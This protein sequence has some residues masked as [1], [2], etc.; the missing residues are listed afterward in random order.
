M[1]VGVDVL[2][3][4][5]LSPVVVMKFLEQLNICKSC[6]P[7]N[8]TPRLLKECANSISSP[9]CTLFNKQLGSGSFPKMWKVANL[10]PVFKF[11][12]KEMVENY[13]GI[14]LLCIISNVFEKCVFSCVF[15]FFQPK[16]YH[17]QDGFVKGR[18]CATRLLRST[19]DFAKALDEKK[20]LDAVFLDYS[21][22]F[23][24]VSFNCLLRELF[25]VGIRGNLLSCFRSYLTDCW[26]RTVDGQAFPLLPISSGVPQGSILGPLLFII[27]INSAPGATDA[28]T[29]VQ[30][31]ADDMKCYRVID[32]DIDAVQLQRDLLSLNS[33]S[34][35]HFMKFNVNKC[36]HLV[37]TKKRNFVH[38]SYNLNGSQI[39]VVSA[40]KD[41]GVHVS[42]NLSWNDHID[43]IIS[44][45]N[46]ML[47]VIYRTCTIECD[48]KTLLI[49]YKSLV[50]PQL[51][52]AS[53][54]WSPYTKDKIMALERVQRSATKFI[55]K[56]DLTYPERLSKLGLF[57]LQL[58]REVLDL[59]FFFK[60]LKGHIDFHVLSYVSFKSYKY[61]MRNTEAILAKGRFRTNVFK[62]SFF[63]RI[64]DLWNGLPV[65][66]RTIE[67]LSLFSKKVN[68][69][70]INKFNLNKEKFL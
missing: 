8:V 67:Q 2:S 54:V 31:Y 62:F 10:L 17:L 15:P 36:K 44:K 27:Y 59:C 26:Y 40:E 14:S 55:L 24:S 68:Q 28:R 23:D 20:Q 3:N 58:R 33:W 38:T 61:Y 1:D 18:S 51:E 5:A 6:G 9:L 49:L 35:E 42:S 13:R 57:P 29:T 53:Q 45:A 16:L 56:C 11:D 39:A 7:D 70:Y 21:K 25:G 34:S 46:K 63:N 65:A 19:F 43:L 4:I 64:V 37:I 12:D 41:L 52:Y 50:R 30:L 22:A 66:I 69:F 48:Q 60:C 32:N 47:G